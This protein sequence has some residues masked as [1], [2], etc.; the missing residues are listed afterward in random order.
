VGVLVMV[1]VLG[2]G[3]MVKEGRVVFPRIGVLIT[4]DIFKLKFSIRTEVLYLN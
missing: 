4:G 3:D 1:W 2:I